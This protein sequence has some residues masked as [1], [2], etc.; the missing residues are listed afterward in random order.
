MG[1]E[2]DILPHVVI[3]GAGFGGLNAALALRHAPCRITVIDKSNHHLFQPL[4]YQV[5]TAGLSPGEIAAPI[6]H[7]LRGHKNTEVLMAEVTGIDSSKKIVELADNRHIPYDYLIISTGARQSY[8]GHDEWS[9]WAPGLKSIADATS[10]RERIL[11]S[12]EQAELEEDPTRQITFVIV[13]GGPT[14]VELAGS[15]AELAKKSMAREFQYVKPETTRIVLVEAG[16]RILATFPA[17]LSEAAAKELNKL[18]IE[19]LITTTVESITEQGVVINGIPLHADM[20]IWAAGVKASPAGAWLHI[21][22]DH[23]G[24]V[25]VNSYLQAEGHPEIYVIGDT[26]L[27]L[28]SHGEPFPGVAPVAMQQGK[29]A[30]SRITAILRGQNPER[31]FHY[32]DKGILATVGRAFAI[33]KIGKLRISGPIAWLVWVFVHIMYLVGFRNRVLVLT[34][35]LWAYLTYQRGV[36][37]IVEENK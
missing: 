9:A 11:R 24:R 17:G 15:I 1:S 8:F 7:I 3:L 22:T 33:A 36:R 29:Y 28:D 26:A 10:I 14:G 2:D 16:P 35:W 32:L 4:L 20:V 37:L 31:P 34:E 13:G 27:A 23:A 21:S 25:P 5:A 19:L 6:R 12:Y 30:G 18:G